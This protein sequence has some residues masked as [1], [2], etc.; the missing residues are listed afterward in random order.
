MLKKLP[1]YRSNLRIKLA[2][3]FSTLVSFLI[4]N[5]F[6]FGTLAISSLFWVILG[7]IIGNLHQTN[8]IHIKNSFLR[9]GF[10]FLAIFLF[11]INIPIC[12][13]DHYFSLGWAYKREGM[14]DE[15]IAYFERATRWNPLEAHYAEAKIQALLERNSKDDAKLAIKEAT[16]WSL[17]LP[18]SSDFY[19][20]KAMGHY[21][22]G[23][24]EKAAHFYRYVVT[25]DPLR[26]E[27]WR[28]L[29]VIYKEVNPPEKGRRNRGKLIEFY[30]SWHKKAPFL[31]EPLIELANLYQQEKKDKI[32]IKLY[33]KV[34]KAPLATSEEK[35]T[36]ASQLA[37]LYYNKGD[38]KGAEE[39]TLEQ[40]SIKPD[41]I[42]A[43]RNL[44]TIYYQ[45][46]EYKKAVA[47]ARTILKY[48]P[49]D[50]YAKRLLS[51]LTK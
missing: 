5:Q 36:A 12:L 32:A 22:L 16:K 8:I 48:S 42:G 19:F 51:V 43:Y 24:K 38:L 34:L 26:L 17:R 39:A 2:A 33:K 18:Y 10:F 28:H 11:L 25:K 45:M 29:S 35:Y 41:N 30:K 9:I 6:S 49:E 40:L 20:W 23:E 13:G 44:A 37:A 21:F 46:K 47:V 14:I 7:A 1:Q 15:A 4:Q 27:A 3:L 31:G 50:E